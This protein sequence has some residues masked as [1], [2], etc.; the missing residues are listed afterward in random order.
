MTVLTNDAYSLQF[1][2]N[3]RKGSSE[4]DGYILQEVK[5]V[6]MKMDSIKNYPENE[7]WHIGD[8]EMPVVESTTHM[9]ISRS[10]SNQ[11]I[12]SNGQY[13]V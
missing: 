7:K 6:V 9:G 1:I 8:K 4:K 13:V 11:E 3:I 2:V 12:E 5:S 10:F